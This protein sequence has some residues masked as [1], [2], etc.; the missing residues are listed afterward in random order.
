MDKLEH[1]AGV[2][3]MPLA[4]DAAVPRAIRN[5]AYWDEYAPWYKLWLEHTDYH[6]G[7]KDLLARIAQPGW[8]VLDIGGGSGVLA[9]PLIRS[10]TEVTVVEPSA[11]MRGFFQAEMA[12]LGLAAVRVIA[13]PWEDVR[14]AGV[15]GFDLALASNSLHLTRIGAARALQRIFE[16]RPFHILVVSET[17]IPFRPG[18]SDRPGY[19]SAA[20][21]SFRAENSFSYHSVEE[22]LRHLDL[23]V[24]HEQDHPSRED[25]IKSLVFKAG[26]F[27]HERSTT[28]RWL[29]LRRKT[30]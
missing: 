21:G 17:E 26:H 15:S 13:A 14:P 8:R 4:L 5:V 10:G 3:A 12:R 28:V 6:R 11:V 27:V 16:A 19:D 25:F 30:D 7:I 29:H 20:S 1:T 24:R 9:L 23:K 2:E 18:A 22:A